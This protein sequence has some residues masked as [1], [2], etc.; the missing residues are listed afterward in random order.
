[1]LDYLRYR[2]LVLLIKQHWSHS[3]SNLTISLSRTRRTMVSQSKKNDC[4]NRT[5]KYKKNLRIY[6]TKRYSYVALFPEGASAE[7]VQI[8]NEIVALQ[9]E[10]VAFR[11]LKAPEIQSEI[12]S[13]SKGRIDAGSI[14]SG[15][16]LRSHASS[17]SSNRK[18]RLAELER[19]KVEEQYEKRAAQLQLQSEV[20]AKQAQL[21]T[22]KQAEEAKMLAQHQAEEAKRQTEEAKRLAQHQAE[23]AKRQIEEAQRREEDAQRIARE[24]KTRAELEQEQQQLNIELQAKNEPRVPSFCLFF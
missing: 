3:S 13:I 8:D 17:T 10:I 11:Q 21:Q 7:A 18:L 9:S 2:L 4:K 15:R 6:K 14:C 5:T 23:E 12:Q 22:K 1:M 24:A 20:E 19:K 16:S